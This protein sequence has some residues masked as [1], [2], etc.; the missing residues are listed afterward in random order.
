MY[1]DVVSIFGNHS[2]EHYNTCKKRKQQQREIMRQQR[3]AC[4]DD[5]ELHHQQQQSNESLTKSLTIHQ[6]LDV[7]RDIVDNTKLVTVQLSVSLAHTT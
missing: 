1:A 6:M 2:L 4:N 3:N 5:E 7:H